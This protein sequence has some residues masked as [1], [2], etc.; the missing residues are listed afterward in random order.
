MN[1]VTAGR[2]TSAWVRKGYRW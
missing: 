2:R 1:P